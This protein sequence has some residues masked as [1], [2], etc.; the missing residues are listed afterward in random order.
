MP[1]EQTY[2]EKGLATKHIGQDKSDAEIADSLAAASMSTTAGKG[3]GLKAKPVDASMPKQKPG[4]SPA[5]FGK[6]MR[7]YREAQNQRKALSK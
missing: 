2:N 6:R 4:E 3:L 1:T 7:E 5:D